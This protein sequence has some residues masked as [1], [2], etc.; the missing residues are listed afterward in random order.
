MCVVCPVEPAVPGA[1]SG[2]H[3]VYAEATS[4]Q[5]GRPFAPSQLCLS[6]TEGKMIREIMEWS[7]NQ[8]AVQQISWHL[9]YD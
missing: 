4:S 2:S 7:G 5:P 3:A 1:C 6:V 8:G 9:P